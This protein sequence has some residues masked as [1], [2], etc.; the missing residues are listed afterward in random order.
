MKGW[1]FESQS[2]RSLS[3]NFGFFFVRSGDCEKFLSL[4][5]KKERRLTCVNALWSR[6]NQ[7][8]TCRTDVEFLP[9][10]GFLFY[11][12]LTRQQVVLYNLAPNFPIE[13]CSWQ[14]G[15]CGNERSVFGVYEQH[16]VVF[17]PLPFN[18]P[19]TSLCLKGQTQSRRCRTSSQEH[20]MSQ[21]G[22]HY[23]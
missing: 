7:S 15:A 8:G 23:I 17:D 20:S 19:H 21:V 3:F 1:R 4:T 10:A 12:P 16:G 14:H 22:S 5:D 13:M 9:L 6:S 18:T 11:S 2:R